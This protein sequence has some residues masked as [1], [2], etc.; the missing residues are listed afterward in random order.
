LVRVPDK[1]GASRSLNPKE[2]GRAKFLY[3]DTCQ[4]PSEVLRPAGL[5]LDPAQRG[6]VG[7]YEILDRTSAQVSEISTGGR[8][9]C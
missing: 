3:P 7:A 2:Y 9:F 8:S 5:I 4:R 6:F 1:V